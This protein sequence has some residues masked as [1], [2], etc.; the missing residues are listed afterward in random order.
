M[1]KLPTWS[2]R[3][4]GWYLEGTHTRHQQATQGRKAGSACM[5]GPNIYTGA[6]GQE[7]NGGSSSSP[8]SGY[9]GWPAGWE[10]PPRVELFLCPGM[11]PTNAPR[12]RGQDF[13]WHALWKTSY[14]ICAPGF[15]AAIPRTRVY[16]R[17]AV[18]WSQLGHS[19]TARIPGA[20]NSPRSAPVRGPPCAGLWFLSRLRGEAG[21]GRRRDIFDRARI[22]CRLRLEVR[23]PAA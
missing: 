23:R 1:V 5:L 13:R 2:S 8:R 17:G 18:L 14:K 21:Q 22:L 3:A 9:I 6:H 19:T 20:R 7:L 10:L 16:P 4:V 15:P 12:I 11:R